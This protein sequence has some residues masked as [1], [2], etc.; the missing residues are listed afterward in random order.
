VTRKRLWLETM[1][2]V[3]AGNRKVVDGS[4]GRTIINLPPA[5][6]ASPATAATVTT[7]DADKGNQP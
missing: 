1:E 6:A 4:D 2:Q 5:P 7:D 3:M